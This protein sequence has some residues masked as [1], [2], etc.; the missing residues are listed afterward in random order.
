[1]AAPARG[2]P[3]GSRS[4]TQHHAS[5]LEARRRRLANSALTPRHHFLFFLVGAPTSRFFDASIATIPRTAIAPVTYS[6]GCGSMPKLRHPCARHAAHRRHAPPVGLGERGA[7]PGVRGRIR[8]RRG[9][10]TRRRAVREEIPPRE[11]PR[12]RVADW[13]AVTPRTRVSCR[14]CATSR[15]LIAPAA[16]WRCL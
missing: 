7:V 9:T 15:D 16:W 2:G 4:A 3:R 1:M 14:S 8:S 5:S 6:S 10:R 13:A 11:A 12:R